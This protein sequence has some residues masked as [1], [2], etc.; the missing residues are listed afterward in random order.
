MPRPGWQKLP[1][2]FHPASWKPATVN[3]A[4]CRQTAFPGGACAAGKY[5]F[6]PP[7]P[8]KRTLRQSSIVNFERELDFTLVILTVA[9]RSD[10][11]EVSRVEEI[12]CPGGGYYAVTRKPGE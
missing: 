3:N 9:Y 1:F 8:V 6:L 10:F 5:P 4:A 2:A 11:S 7:N 12:E